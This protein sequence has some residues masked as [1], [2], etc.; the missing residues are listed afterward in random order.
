MREEDAD[1]V[2]TLEEEGRA[3]VEAVHELGG[4][5]AGWPRL[6]VVMRDDSEYALG[7]VT[8][9]IVR[10]LPHRDRSYIG[11]AAEQRLREL[12]LPLG[13]PL[14]LTASE[15]AAAIERAEER[16]Q[17]EPATLPQEAPKAARV[18]PPPFSIPILRHY[19]RGHV[20]TLSDRSVVVLEVASDPFR[21]PSPPPV[22]VV[23]SGNDDTFKRIRKTAP[24]RVKLARAVNVRLAMEAIEGASPVRILCDESLALGDGGLLERIESERPQLL[25]ALEI[26]CPEGSADWLSNYLAKRAPG[27][28]VL[29]E[30]LVEEDIDDLVE[31]SKAKG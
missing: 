27:I 13:E 20:W 17:A 7:S 15:R 10:A 18:E 21:S 11:V 1:L 24:A 22:I 9:L 31:R 8:G 29:E 23:V 25:P 12:W 28:R 26:L 16:Q 3:W 14:R 2:L 6:M 30:P 5:P 19:E 4:A